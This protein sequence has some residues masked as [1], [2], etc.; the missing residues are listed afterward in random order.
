MIIY[1]KNW[2]NRVNKNILKFLFLLT[3]ITFVLLGACVPTVIN[4]FISIAYFF[5]RPF[6]NLLGTKYFKLFYF[7]LLIVGSALII[8]IIF[9]FFLF[10]SERIKL[11]KCKGNRH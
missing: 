7:F 1:I 5:Y 4:L 10:L 3:Y 9:K 2:N 8:R 6:L 11:R